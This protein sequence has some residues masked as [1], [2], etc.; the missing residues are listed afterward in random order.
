MSP[1]GIC[2]GVTPSLARMVPPMPPMRILRPL[3]SATV[4][5]SFLYQPP[6]CTPVLPHGM[7]IM[8]YCLNT[9]RSSSAP[10]PQLNHAA[11]WRAL[12]PNGIP[13]SNANAGFLPMKNDDS[14]WVA[15]MVP[16][17][18]A[19]NTWLPGTISPAVMTRISNLPSVIA[20]I[21]LAIA[22]TPPW[23][24]SR[25]LGQLVCRRH[26]TDGADWAIAGAAIA[27]RAAPAPAFVRNSRLFIAFSLDR[28]ARP[29]GKQPAG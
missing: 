11:C 9:S 10:P 26:F 24:V 21:R 14:V 1:G 8:P 2:C 22:S 12:S 25:L 5:I 23:V 4:L 28:P 13:A 16:F 29:A 17:S 15:S 19:S 27:P 7:F 20:A 3:R 18:T 6:I